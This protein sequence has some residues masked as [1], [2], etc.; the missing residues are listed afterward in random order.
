VKKRFATQPDAQTILRQVQK[1]LAVG[2]CIRIAVDSGEGDSL[3]IAD[4]IAAL[5]SLL[6]A[7]AAMLDPP[8]R[9]PRDRRNG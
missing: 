5:L 1:A 4:A 2:A 3:D 9:T 6:E 7:T 8:R